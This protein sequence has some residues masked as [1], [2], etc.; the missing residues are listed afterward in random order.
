LSAA[1]GGAYTTPRRYGDGVSQVQLRHVSACQLPPTQACEIPQSSPADAVRIVDHQPRRDS[2][3][4]SKTKRVKV[5]WMPLLR[6]GASAGRYEQ[7]QPYWK[8]ATHMLSTLKKRSP[9]IGNAPAPARRPRSF[10]PWLYPNWFESDASSSQAAAHDIGLTSA[11]RS[12]DQL[13]SQRTFGF[14]PF[15]SDAAIGLPFPN[16]SNLSKR[17]GIF[18]ARSTRVVP[19]GVCRSRRC[20]SVSSRR[21]HGRDP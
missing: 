17:T 7:V 21:Q 20:L 13:R 15:V 10:A 6:G 5:T 8:F 12:S 19:S 2:Q 4:S 18:P 14:A 3:V 9:A 1:D 16:L 11:H